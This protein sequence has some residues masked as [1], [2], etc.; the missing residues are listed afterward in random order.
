[1]RVI[2]DNIKKVYRGKTAIDVKL[3]LE[4]GKI[5]AVIGQNGSG[6]TTLMRI[7]AGLLEPDSGRVQYC[8]CENSPSKDLI[9]YLPQKPYIFD[10]SVFDNVKVGIQGKENIESNVMDALRFVG[11]DAFSDQNARTLSG[12]EAQRMAVA[13]T[14][15]L[16]KKFVLLDEPTASIDISNMHWVERYIL[17]VNKKDGSTVVINTHNPSQ[18]Y[19]IADRVIFLKN[20]SVAEQGDKNILKSPQSEELK[21]FLNNWRI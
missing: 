14:L 1:M 5:T 9:A 21:E 7:L 17:D 3:T 2:L 18:A 8:D 13:R 4:S 20:G 6:K 12:G 15:I 10:L 16:G 11:M 19:R